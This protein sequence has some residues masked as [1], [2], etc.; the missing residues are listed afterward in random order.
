MQLPLK[1]FLC[2]HSSF[3]IIPP[4][5]AAYQGG[6]A[7]HPPVEGAMGDVGE[8]GD[9]S[10]KNK[11]YCEL[12]VQYYAWKNEELQSYGFCHY[13]RFF[14]F[15]EAVKKPYLA[16]KT[17]TGK[18]KKRYLKT[19]ADIERLIALQDIITVRKEKTADTVYNYYCTAPHQYKED[20]DLFIEILKEKYPHLSAACDKY[21]NGSSQYFCNMFIMSREYFFSYC[22]MLFDILACFDE[23]KQLHGYFQADRTD[24]YL[25]ERFLGIFITYAYDNGARIKELPRI[26]THCTLKKRVIYHLLPPESRLRLFLKK[27][28]S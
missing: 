17:L 20:I 25:A 4:F 11:E 8:K 9:I 10:A 13:R 15:D 7:I 18:E 24:G 21:M 3:D 19:E 12:T 2:C 5:A 28:F 6:S 23:K 1:I 26:D 16:K 22:E 14:C 27:R